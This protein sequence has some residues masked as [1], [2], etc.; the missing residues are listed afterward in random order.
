VSVPEAKARAFPG[1]RMG[2]EIANAWAWLV[3]RAPRIARAL[4]DTP[5][6]AK[7]FA[8]VMAAFDFF[9]RR[10]GIVTRE[11]MRDVERQVTY[12]EVSDTIRISQVYRR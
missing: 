9:H 12:D 3:A 4:D 2:N 8:D 1:A 5:D 6:A 10:Y 7:V 11:Q